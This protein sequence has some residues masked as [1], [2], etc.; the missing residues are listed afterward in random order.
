MKKFLKLII[1]IINLPFVII[2]IIDSKNILKEHK[3][4]F[5]KRF[6]LGFRFCYNHLR[7]ETGTPPQISLIMAMKLLTISPNI[8]GVVVECGTFKGGNAANLSIICKMV[9]R[10]LLIMDS[11]EGLPEL[12]ADDREAKE[13]KKGEWCGSLNE[14]K[15]NIRR[16]GNIEV[17]EFIQ[18]WF[19][20]TMPNLK[21]SIVLA[22]LDVDLEASL[23]TCVRYIWP[24]LVEK[25]YL[26]SDEC[27]GTGYT[28]LF[29]SEKWWKNNFNQLP[30]GFIG[31][32]TGL[33]F[34][35]VYVGP[36][37]NFYKSKNPF[38]Q[39]GTGGYTFKGMIG[40]WSYYK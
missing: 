5:M 32:G 30:P 37:E 29:Y 11:F 25:G 12:D 10:R 18:G 16:Y 8:K 24:N 33:S 40:Y 17:C 36:Y 39:P 1:T 9:G 3:I 22:Y 21:E 34:G 2:S 4:G 13:Y 23:D 27:V 20:D 38:Q 19:S 35:N 26:F 31:A 28:S 7:V 15:K 6:V 14:V